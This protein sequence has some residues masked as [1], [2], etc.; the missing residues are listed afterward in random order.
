M[1]TTRPERIVLRNYLTRLPE[2]AVRVTRPSRFGNPFRVE[3]HGLQDAIRLHREWLLT[4]T[5]PIQLGRHT[6]SPVRV[7]N[8]LHLLRGK[9]LA[10]TCPAGQPC[11]ADTLIELANR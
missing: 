9:H 1:T 2:G 3:V 8:E 4:G 11:H 5:E 7:R 6:Y 10:C